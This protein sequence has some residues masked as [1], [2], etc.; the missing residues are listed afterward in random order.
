MPEAGPPS[1]LFSPLSFSSLESRVI[2]RSTYSSCSSVYGKDKFR[3]QMN[4]E[5][6]YLVLLIFLKLRVDT[7]TFNENAGALIGNQRSPAGEQR[8]VFPM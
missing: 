5:E 1:L 4:P 3:V 7:L 6:T 2:S 8:A